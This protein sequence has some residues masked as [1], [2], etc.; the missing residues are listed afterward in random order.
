MASSGIE[1]SISSPNVNLGMVGKMAWNR[2]SRG[3]SYRRKST[4]PPCSD[5]HFPTRNPIGV[6]S[7]DRR[8]R[9]YSGRKHLF[10]ID[11]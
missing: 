10:D 9:S 8:R 5:L 7:D 1:I 6:S 11:T 2:G 3:F 4:F